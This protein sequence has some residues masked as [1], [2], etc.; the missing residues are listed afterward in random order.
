MRP[1]LKIF[2]NEDA[3]AKLH[4]PNK[5]VYSLSV[6]D[7]SGRGSK[8]AD[9][10]TIRDSCWNEPITACACKSDKP[11]T[12]QAG[13]IHEPCT[14]HAIKA[15]EAA[16]ACERRPRGIRTP[17]QQRTYEERQ[18]Q[19]RWQRDRR[20]RVNPAAPEEERAPDWLRK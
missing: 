16:C 18:R 12:R 6:K 14:R 19:Q 13:Q 17:E 10:I 4:S 15:S 3:S 8:P 9:T 11:T 5:N 2:W 20:C 7:E 1:E